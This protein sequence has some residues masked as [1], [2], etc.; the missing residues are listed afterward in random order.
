[1]P[2]IIEATTASGGKERIKLPVEIWERNKSFVFTIPTTEALNSVVIDPE[3]VFPD[4]NPS[5]NSWSN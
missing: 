4:I 1:M 3:K 5:N 2:L